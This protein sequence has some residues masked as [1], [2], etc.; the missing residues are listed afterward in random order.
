MANKIEAIVDSIQVKTEKTTRSIFLFC[1]KILTVFIVGL[2]LA[3]IGQELISYGTISFIFI[4][5]VISFSLLKVMSKWTM[6]SVLVFD[7][8]C[9]LIAFLLRMYI[10]VAP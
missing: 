1:L 9:V 5:L 4:L 10:L 7:L 8:F 3:M 6:G 2:T